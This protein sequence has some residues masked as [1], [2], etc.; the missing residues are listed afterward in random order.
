MKKLPYPAEIPGNAQGEGAPSSVP[1]VPNVV[2]SVNVNGIPAAYP[3]VFSLPSI[4]RKT[5]GQFEVSFSGCPILS[6]GGGIVLNFSIWRDFG[7]GSAFNV[8]TSGTPINRKIVASGAGQDA[9]GAITPLVDTVTD[10]LPH[11]Y[12][13]VVTNGSSTTMSDLAGHDNGTVKEL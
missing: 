8:G 9:Q 2:S 3:F 13:L 7:T 12:S 10:Y 11:V 1:N 4:T 5:S 6:G